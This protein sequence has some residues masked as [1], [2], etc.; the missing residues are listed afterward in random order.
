MT[1]AERELLEAALEHWVTGRF[2]HLQRAVVKERETMPAL[3]EK[4]MLAFYR[5]WLKAQLAIKAKKPKP[6]RVVK[7]RRKR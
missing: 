4:E 5:P 7:K 3:T 6:I 1:K 2:A